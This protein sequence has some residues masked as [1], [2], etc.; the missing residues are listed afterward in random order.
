ME[1]IVLAGGYGT[2][3]TCVPAGCPKV[4]APVRGVPFVEHLLNHLKQ[5]GIS[6]I[7]MCVGYRGQEV[8]RFLGGG[9]QF[10]LSIEYSYDDEHQSDFARGAAFAVRRACRLVQEPFF[11]VNGDTLVPGL[12]APILEYHISSGYLATIAVYNN[13]NRIWPSNVELS[14]G[15]VQRYS[16]KAQTEE[17]LFIDAGVGIFCAEVFELCGG[18]TEMPDVLSALSNLGLLG[19]FEMSSRFYEINTPASLDD[20]EHYL[21]S[22]EKS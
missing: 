20:M 11:V 15:R 18:V 4:L 16:K 9:E 13:A 21:A 6:R 22:S 3:L 10:G 14:N 19:G 5:Q 17:T 8:E 1:A 7:V 2:R 12:W